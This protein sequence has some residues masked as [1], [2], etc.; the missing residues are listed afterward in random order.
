MM[1][2]AHMAGQPVAKASAGL[3][4]TPKLTIL[5]TENLSPM[6]TKAVVTIQ[7][8]LEFEDASS[9]PSVATAGF[10]RDKVLHGEFVG[11]AFKPID[12]KPSFYLAS[13]K[14]KS[15]PKKGKYKLL[16]RVILTGSERTIESKA[17]EVE[18]K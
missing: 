18:V 3:E 1:S 16:A 7:V 11:T 6:A 5:H 13:V 9:L 15:P 14:I 2:C 4:E 8:E 10:E 17:I 12:G